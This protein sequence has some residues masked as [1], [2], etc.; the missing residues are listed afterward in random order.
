MYVIVMY[1]TAKYETTHCGI[2]SSVM[3]MPCDLV[4]SRHLHGMFWRRMLLLEHKYWV[5]GVGKQMWV[6]RIL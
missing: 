5:F 4:L 1:V 6:S 3:D 2:T